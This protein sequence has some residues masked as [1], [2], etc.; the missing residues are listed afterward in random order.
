MKKIEHPILCLLTALALAS[1]CTDESADMS[2]G[3]P[4]I[5][6][7][8]PFTG[9][10]FGDNLPF[11]ASVTDRVPLSTLTARLFFGD[12]QVSQ[13]VIRTKENGD[14][15]GSVFVPF[16]KNVPDGTATLEL[17]LTDT[18]L[19]IARQSFELPVSR[20]AYPYLILVTADGSYPMRPTGVP[21]EYAATEAFSSTDLPA[22]IKTPAFSDRGTE[23]IFGWEGGEITQGANT[24][25]PF[26]SPQASPYSVTFNTL[27]Y[28]A[29]P[30]FELLVNG[31]KLAMVDKENFSIDLDLRQGQSLTVEGLSDIARWWPDPDFF[32]PTPDSNTFTFL[33]IDG[34]Y[35]LTANTTHRY[36]NV[37]VMTGSTLATLEPD[38]SGAIWVIGADIG[39]PSIA[40]ETGWNT[41]KAL[42]MAPA[43]NGIYH[44][45]LV[46]GQTVNA[47]GINF[48]FFHQKGWGG[49]FTTNLTTTSDIVFVGAGGDSGRDP[50]N[51]GILP[52]KTLDEGATYVFT[53]DV[54]AG[55]DHALLTVTKL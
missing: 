16:Y 19:S 53:L 6:T 45:T 50:G 36:F 43:G 20:P 15:S 33:P 14:Y 21:H 4:L 42:C 48:K 54:S 8:T 9:A 17:T 23:I 55:T 3:N 34:K 44:L 46:A 29:G 39:K 37:E 18:H 27:T 51:L 28:A 5:E 40:N 11:T 38:G 10:Y 25:I 12:E 2:P 41:D 47:S 1:S 52:G 49:E 32:A 22:C 30:F 31:E 35:R 13:T 7:K 24:E 26:V